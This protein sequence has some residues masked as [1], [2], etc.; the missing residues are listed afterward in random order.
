MVAVGLGLALATTTAWAGPDDGF[1]MSGDA[2]MRG[3]AAVVF[4]SD[5]ASVW[6]NPA[7]AAAIERSQFDFSVSAYG[8]KRT[9]IDDAMVAR[10]GERELAAQ[11]K[12]EQILVVP[13]GVGHGFAFPKVGM[14]LVLHFH[15]PIYADVQS[16]VRV[17]G[18]DPV[19]AERTTQELNG[20]S[21]HRRYHFGSTIGWTPNHGRFRMG[22]TTGGLYD[23]NSEFTRLAVLA[24]SADES[25]KSGIVIDF[26]Q[27]S[28]VVGLEM[29]FGVAGVLG[30]H[31]QGGASVRS[32]AF[33]VWRRHVGGE[34]LAAVTDDGSLS[35]AEIIIDGVTQEPVPRWLT[36]WRISAGL[37]WVYEDLVVEVD[38]ELTTRKRTGAAEWRRPLVWNL[39][40][41]A[42]YSINDRF[43]FGLGVFTDRSTEIEAPLFPGV[44][45]D[46]W[47]MSAGLRM[48][49]PVKLGDGERARDLVF[50]TTLA[51]QFSG[52]V[53]RGQPFI[54][55]Y[56]P[57]R[58]VVESVNLTETHRA[59]QMMLLVNVGSG[60]HF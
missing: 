38:G 42:H 18:E 48:R 52:G 12:D 58:P 41:G 25:S 27:A 50:Y 28:Q 11:G 8:M 44:K 1:H 34:T 60:L 46:R 51:A 54:I 56:D 5:A 33:G 23:S 47:G 53:G 6:Y 9:R 4:S 55:E 14:S 19:N 43:S 20:Y 21:S 45:V 29:G 16:R 22:L 57:D 26:D 3:G 35:D 30:K 13:T 7:A 15:T 31:L 37:A 10:R 49:S 39:R 40:A 32:P 36:P 59:T 17:E 24:Q 2:S